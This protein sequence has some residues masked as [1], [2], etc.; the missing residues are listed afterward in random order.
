VAARAAI[1]LGSNLGDRRALM[2][3]AVHGLAAGAGRL[4]AVS[5]LYETE[6]IGGP[7]QG[8]YLNAVAVVDTHL[9]P[10]HLLQLCLDLE[11]GAGRVRRVRWEAR[12]LD[13]DVLLYDEVEISE[14][15]LIVPHPRMRERRFVL[16]PLVEAWP[17]AAFPGGAA[18]VDLLLG[19]SSQKVEIHA[20][21]GWWEQ[22]A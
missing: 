8:R 22:P 9:D 2:A 11:Q 1:G 17:K 15:G 20:G 19:V 16:E 4:L 10:L 12:T 21:P 13:V 7:G 5:S 6:P 3:Q 18:V 14:P